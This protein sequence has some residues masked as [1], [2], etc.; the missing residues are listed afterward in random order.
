[1]MAGM[2]MYLLWRRDAD[3]FKCHNISEIAY[4]L[5]VI[6]ILIL[7]YVAV[8]VEYSKYQIPVNKLDSQQLEKLVNLDIKSTQQ[9]E[10][11]YVRHDLGV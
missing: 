5:G 8:L 3:P 7:V 6:F 11:L 4:V 10:C 9:E 1:M 2:V